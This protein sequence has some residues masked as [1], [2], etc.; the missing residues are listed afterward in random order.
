MLQFFFWSIVELDKKFVWNSFG[1]FFD[2][3][4]RSFFFRISEF[5]LNL[6]ENIIIEIHFIFILYVNFNFNWSRNEA[7]IFVD[8]GQM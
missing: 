8:S 4:A 5:F 3:G 2:K 6:P 1:Y 7:K